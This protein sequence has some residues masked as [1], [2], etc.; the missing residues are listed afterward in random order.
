MVFVRVTCSPF[1]LHCS[2]EPDLKRFSVFVVY[3]IP[4][5]FEI[6]LFPHIL[7]KTSCSLTLLSSQQVLLFLW[8][9]VEEGRDWR[10]GRLQVPFIFWNTKSWFFSPF[11]LLLLLFIEVPFF[12]NC[13]F[14]FLQSCVNFCCKV[15][16]F[17]HTY[18]DSFFILVYHR[19]LNIVSRLI[20]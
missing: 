9:R 12:L 20:Q 14:F 6:I 19:I 3:Q 15:R 2:P 16:W 1:S 13:S 4:F 10:R 18:M 5:L 8:K 7:I 11:F 17:N